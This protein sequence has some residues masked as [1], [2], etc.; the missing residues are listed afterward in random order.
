MRS[1]KITVILKDGSPYG[2][3]IAEV[4]NWNGKIIFAP[5]T[6]LKKLKELPEKDSPAVYF[7]LGENN[8]VYVGKTGA[9]GERLSSHNK[10]KEFWT[11]LIAFISP[12][13]SSTEVE[14]LE[15]VFYQKLKN[16]GLSNLKNNSQPPEPTIPQEDKDV[17]SDFVDRASDVLM[18]LGYGFIG[19]SEE[20]VHSSSAG[21]DIICK[22]GGA[23]GIGTLSDNGL[24]LRK[25]SLIRKRMTSSI[26]DSSKRVREELVNSKKLI[27][28]DDAENYILT[29]DH[30]FS[31]PS[32]ASSVV[33]GRSSNGL[34][35]W[36]TLEGVTLKE[37]EAQED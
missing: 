4:S 26:S 25:D 34:T 11:E 27:N 30:L 35:Q 18:S 33:L 14:Y 17:L 36:K 32:A 2:V 6:A 24:L 28:S 13:H 9:L 16:D 7:L 3:R 5:R 12:K 19:A 15:S 10:N 20:L 31:S 29:E 21:L 37:L 23:R 1:K 22:G 8:D